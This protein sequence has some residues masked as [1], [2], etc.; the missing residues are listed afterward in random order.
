MVKKKTKKNKIHKEDI[1]RT[2]VVNIR[3]VLDNKKFGNSVTKRL[4]FEEAETVYKFLEDK[5]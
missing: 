4:S 3:E 1:N 5:K 2:Y